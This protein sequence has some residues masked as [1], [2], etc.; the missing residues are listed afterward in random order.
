[1]ERD[2]RLGKSEEGLKAE[3][4][5]EIDIR[6]ILEQIGLDKDHWPQ[7]WGGKSEEKLSS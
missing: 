5:L 2:L 3:R 7:E 1:M 4:K 6:K